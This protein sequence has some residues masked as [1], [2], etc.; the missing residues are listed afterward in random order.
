MN[1]CDFGLALTGSSS[2]LHRALDAGAI[3]ASSL[4]TQVGR[5]EVG[6]FVGGMASRGHAGG[7]QTL[8]GLVLLSVTPAASQMRVPAGRPIMDVGYA[9]RARSARLRSRH[10]SARRPRQ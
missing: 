8:H 9:G 1:L 5:M 10:E 6:H 2:I 4:A 3:E 7:H